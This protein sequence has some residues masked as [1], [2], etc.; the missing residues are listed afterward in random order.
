MTHSHNYKY[1]TFN[2]ESA[3]QV[4]LSLKETRELLQEVGEREGERE[5]EGERDRGRGGGGE[6]RGV[7][8]RQQYKLCTCISTKVGDFLHGR[9]EQGQGV[10]EPWKD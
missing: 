10:I 7:C 2:R 3:A 6:R 4:N 5:T 1:A 9:D 8:I